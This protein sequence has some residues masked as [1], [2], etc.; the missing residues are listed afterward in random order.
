MESFEENLKH[1]FSS[2]DIKFLKEVQSRV[3]FL[4]HARYVLPRVGNI[5]SPSYIISRGPFSYR[6]VLASGLGSEKKYFLGEN[7]GSQRRKLWTAR[8]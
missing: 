6:P 3:S 7:L 1:E 8:E 4:L 5:Q 2:D